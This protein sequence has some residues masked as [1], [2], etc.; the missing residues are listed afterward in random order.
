MCIFCC[1]YHQL[2]PLKSTL[3]MYMMVLLSWLLASDKKNCPTLTCLKATWSSGNHQFVRVSTNY[4]LCEEILRF[5]QS[6]TYYQ[7]DPQNQRFSVMRNLSSHCSSYIIVIKVV[8][9]CLKE[10]IRF[11]DPRFNTH[12]S[13]F[14][15]K[16][17][18]VAYPTWDPES[19]CQSQHTILGR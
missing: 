7:N 5:N 16:G 18:Q 11:A 6:W 10:R 14:S 3:T 17:S 9:K 15:P 19:S 1:C 13:A 2:P 4:A 12:C 8:Y